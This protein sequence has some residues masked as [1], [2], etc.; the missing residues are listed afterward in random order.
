LLLEEQ[1]T[2]QDERF[3]IQFIGSCRTPFSRNNV[4]RAGLGPMLHEYI[5][6]EAMNALGISTTR[7]LAVVTTGESV[8]RETELSGAIL[9]QCLSP[10]SISKDYR[11]FGDR[12]FI[13]I[14]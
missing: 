7:S 3:D 12:H 14:W 9:I 4:G 2:P 6:S 13:S 11:L 10:R 5:I 8:F 1:I